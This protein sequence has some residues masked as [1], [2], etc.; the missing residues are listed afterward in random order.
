MIEIYELVY[1]Y[2]IGYTVAKYGYFSCNENMFIV[3]TLFLVFLDLLNFAAGV[4]SS[5]ARHVFCW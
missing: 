4:I 5:G 2:I 3:G 1:Q